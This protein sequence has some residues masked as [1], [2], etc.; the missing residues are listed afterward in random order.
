MLIVSWLWLIVGVLSLLVVA[1]VMPDLFDRIQQI[2]GATNPQAAEAMGFV[3]GCVFV[4]LGLIYVV[5]PGIFLLFYRSPHVRATVESRDPV[6]RWTDRAPAPVLALSLILG[7]AAVALLASS[8]MGAVPAFGQ[9]LTGA[10]A[11]LVL[12]V[13]AA[14]MAVLAR[15]VYRLEPWSWW[16]VAAFWLLGTL[17]AVSFVFGDFDWRSFYD[18]MGLPTAEVEKLG[19]FEMLQGPA[20]KV[21]V[22]LWTVAVLGYLLWIRRFFHRP[23]RPAPLP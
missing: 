1:F 20:M 2:E 13:L 22:G 21:L 7:Y 4:V 12:V 5:L 8:A 11:I 19:L 23:E 17:S 14:M 18:A 9:V 3:R 6:P 16:A 15:A 10:T